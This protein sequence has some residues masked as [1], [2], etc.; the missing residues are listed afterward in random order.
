MIY[1]AVHR[2]TG[3]VSLTMNVG[4]RLPLFRSAIGR[5]MMSAMAPTARDEILARVKAAGRHDMGQVRADLTQAAEEYAAHGY[6]SSFGDWTPNVSGIAVPVLSLN[7]DR[8][9]AMNLGAPS[10]L[11]SEAE[12][13][14]VHAPRL[15]AAGRSLSDVPGRL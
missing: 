6:C 7:G 4:A 8:L 10:F 3:D 9:F 11:T 15:I 13:R 5:A 12:M 14:E 2:A 1:T